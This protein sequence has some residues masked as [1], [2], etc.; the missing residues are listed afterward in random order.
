MGVLDAQTDMATD[1]I[2]GLS[3][4]S[5][6]GLPSFLDQLAQSANLTEKTFS[7]CMVS[8]YFDV[9]L[10]KKTLISF[11]F[12]LL[13]IINIISLNSTILANEAS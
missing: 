13:K 7:L 1:G 5:P 4:A 6:G 3:P 12:L 10:K 9:I 2:F 8:L 11:F